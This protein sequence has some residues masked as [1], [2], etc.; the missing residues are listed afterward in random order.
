[1]V[2]SKSNEYP[3][4]EKSQSVAWGSVMSLLVSSLP[5]RAEASPDELNGLFCFGGPLAIGTQPNK[6]LDRNRVDDAKAMSSAR[7]NNALETGVDSFH[8]SINNQRKKI[9]DPMNWQT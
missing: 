1:M 8:A 3:E 6:A 9:T 4:T 5:S 2:S 7:K